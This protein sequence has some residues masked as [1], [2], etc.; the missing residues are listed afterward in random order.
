MRATLKSK[1]RGNE[2]GVRTQKLGRKECTEVAN[3]APFPR[4]GR[5][6]AVNAYQVLLQSKSVRQVVGCAFC[7]CVE[8][9]GKWLA[10]RH[11]IIRG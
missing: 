9:K 1:G 3:D 4:T 7:H 8:C 10:R 5:R 2:L 6:T 11:K